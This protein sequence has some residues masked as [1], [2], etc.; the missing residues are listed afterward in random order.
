MSNSL[1][2]LFLT[3]TLIFLSCS[4]TGGKA[5]RN[6]LIPSKDVVSILTD[7]YIADGLLSIQ[8]VR[9]KYSAKDS[10][11]NYIEI[12]ESHGYTKDQLD[13]TLKHYF[14]KNPKELEKIYDE[15]LAVLSEI[16]SRLNTEIA[17]TPDAN[18]NLWSKQ[19][20]YSL[21]E[22]GAN[23]SIYFN[24]PVKDTGL[25]ELSLTA[26]VFPDDQSLN[27]RIK[28]F[29]NHKDSTK[30][31]EKDFWDP[32]ILPKDGQR[33]N[34]TLTNR[35]SDTTSASFSG[36]LL[37]NDTRAGIWKKHAK[38]ENIIFRKVLSQ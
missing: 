23:N 32:V 38:I 20:S 25:Y 6:Q 15:V 16:Q 24:I 19:L 26:I 13:K 1:K 36:W 18:L 35:L 2:I 5:K 11:A 34:Y 22:E 8:S 10:I 28:V 14:V 37:Y 3:I 33:H 17:K 4:G 21:P 31:G 30:K 9:I 12:I 29:F 27:P 7:L